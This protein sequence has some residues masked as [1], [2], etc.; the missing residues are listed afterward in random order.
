MKPC[1]KK[2]PEKEGIITRQQTMPLPASC[3]NPVQPLSA[4]C[5]VPRY[6]V[7]WLRHADWIDWIPACASMTSVVQADKARCHPR[8]YDEALFRQMK[9]AVTPGQYDEALFKQMMLAII[10]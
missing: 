9:P 2:F 6:V 7:T 10:P 4:S 3:I 8:W 5:I 1:R